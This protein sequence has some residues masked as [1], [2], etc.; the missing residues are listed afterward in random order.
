MLVP[1]SSCERSEERVSIVALRYISNRNR[2]FVCL[3]T[4]LLCL[5]VCVCECAFVVA[6]STY[7]P[8]I[9]NRGLIDWGAYGPIAFVRRR[10]AGGIDLKPK[11]G[12]Q[13][14]VYDFLRTSETSFSD[15]AVNKLNNSHLC[16]FWL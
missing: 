14:L 12:C 8:S 15:T 13:T 11:S 5:Y 1:C 3:V 2:G 7:T 9:C 16:I 6:A 4:S 10:F